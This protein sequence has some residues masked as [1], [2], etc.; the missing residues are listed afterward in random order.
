MSDF[1]TSPFDT[2]ASARPRRTLGR[3]EPMLAEAPPRSMQALDYRL[4]A[5]MRLFL[6]SA[7][8]LVVTLV[9]AEHGRWA[10]ATY[11]M[12]IAYTLFAAALYGVQ[13]ARRRA[14]T[15]L[16]NWE[17][18]IDV[19]W[20]TA[21]ITLSGGA[22][23]IFFYGFFF[24]ILVASF[25]WGFGAG[26]RVTLVSTFLF[27]SLGYIAAPPEPDFERQRFLIRPAFLLA[28]GYM[29]ASRG[30]FEVKLRARL[31]FLKDV[32]T[33]SNA[34]F[35]M[36]RTV[37]V[38]IHRVMRLYGAD[39]CA[40]ITKDAATGLHELRHIRREEPEGAVQADSVPAELAERLL[41]FPDDFAVEFSKPDRVRTWP[42]AA[43]ERGRRVPS[44]PEEWEG[45]EVCELLAA[46]LEADSF[47]GV[48]FVLPNLGI[49]WLWLVFDGKRTFDESDVAFLVQV[50]EHAIPAIENI[51]L[52]DRLA[53]SAAEEERKRIARDIHDS[54]I[55]PYVG[56][57]IGLAGL[58]QKVRTQGQ[59]AEVEVERLIEMTGRGIDD[60]RNQVSTLRWGGGSGEG[61]VPA[62]TRFAAKYAEATGIA[63]EVVAESDIPVDDRVAGEAFQMVAEA[64]SNVRRHSNANRATVRLG[65]RG[66]N[67]LLAVEDEGAGKAPF[68]PFR[69]RSITERAEA[70]GGRVSVEGRDDGGAIVSVKIPL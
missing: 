53:S 69:P 18:W 60:L 61:L 23:S 5:G 32:G 30:G 52:T 21:I 4:V 50:V 12:L 11:G 31:R 40:M 34:R 35:G 28:L 7:G 43:S 33:V 14:G 25:R 29:M 6:A 13:V 48:P 10:A 44:K 17:H 46:V 47:L 22:N 63:V 54:V 64:L 41:R 57:R 9:P 67:L 51:R 24:P 1:G 36:D 56:L 20:Y 37:G 19:G 3:S 49:G 16:L 55:Q 62:V 42:V 26:I 27:T 2:V 66:G 15:A 39:S 70:L 58:R 45:Q 68:A 65:C 59:D 38:L 8:L